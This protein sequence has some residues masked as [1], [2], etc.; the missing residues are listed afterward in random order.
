MLR[1]HADLDVPTLRPKV[2][3]D[4]INW[5]EADP[6]EYRFK[7]GLGLATERAAAPILKKEVN[8]WEDLL[9]DLRAEG[10]SRLQTAQDSGPETKIAEARGFQAGVDRMERA[11]VFVSLHPDAG[12]PWYGDREAH[13]RFDGMTVAGDPVA[14]KLF[15]QNEK[16]QN[17]GWQVW[18]KGNFGSTQ[19][20]GA[21]LYR[22]TPTTQEGQ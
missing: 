8:T 3:E 13:G 1:A 19:I 6:E 2:A 10:A 15:I 5:H 16:L 11:G 22:K 9:A 12:H 17:A 7:I 4:P 20:G 21:Y 14:V 18:Q